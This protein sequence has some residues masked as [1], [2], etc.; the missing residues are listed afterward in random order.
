MTVPVVCVGAAHWDLI[1]RTSAPLPPGADVPGRITRQPGG[2]AQNV[3]RALA[4][5][6]RPVALLAA[7]GRDAAGDDL[8]RALTAAGVDCASA[9]RHAGATDA[10]LAIEGRDGALH[11]GVADCGGLERAG[12]AILAPL[13]DGRLAAAQIVADGNL[14]DPVLREVLRLAEQAAFALVP[15]SPRKAARLAPLL[16]ARPLTL[17]LNRLEAE[18]LCAAAFPDSRAAAEAVRALG[19]AEAVVTDGAAPATAA[20]SAGTVSLAPPPVA[21]RSLTGAGDVFVAAHLAARADGLGPGEALRAA[22]AA[23]AR[24]VACEVP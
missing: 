24:H 17:Y 16:G 19:A 8:V 20:G 1:A 6:G 4:A 21:T 11:A 15:A 13:G 18:A 2:V 12:A 5:L 14:P 9:H 22:L 10:Y 3:A 23:S 7:I